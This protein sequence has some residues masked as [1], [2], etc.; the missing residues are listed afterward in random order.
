MSNKI[1]ELSRSENIQLM[2]SFAVQNMKITIEE[3]INA[4][5]TLN[6][7]NE[8]GSIHIG[9]RADILIFDM[10]DNKHLIYNFGVNLI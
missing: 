6:I 9:N 7:S 3:I 8:T 10:K 2:M 1:I 5:A 4:A